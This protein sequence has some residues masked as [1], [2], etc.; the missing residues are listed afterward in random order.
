M[1]SSRRGRE[2][3]SS[4]S[5]ESRKLSASAPSDAPR[6]PSA[7]ET[8]RGSEPPRGSGT[9]T[10]TSMGFSAPSLS[11]TVA[12]N[13]MWR[14]ETSSRVGLFGLFGLF[15]G[16]V[17]FNALFA[18]DEAVPPGAADEVSP[19]RETAR[20][21]S[22]D[23]RTRASPD[24]RE[25]SVCPSEPRRRKTTLAA[26]DAADARDAAPR[27]SAPPSP[28]GGARPGGA[29]RAR[30]RRLEPRLHLRA[31]ALPASSPRRRRAS[32]DARADRRV[33]ERARQRGPGG[34]FARARAAR[35]PRPPSESASSDPPKRAPTRAPSAPSRGDSGR[36]SPR[37][38]GFLAVGTRRRGN[39][40]RR[41]RYA[42]ARG[43]LGDAEPPERLAGG[44]ARP[45][46]R[47]PPP[48]HSPGT[49]RSTRRRRAPASGARS[50]A[51]SR[52][53]SAGVV[54]H[55]GFS[56][57]FSIAVPRA[58]AC[59]RAAPAPPRVLFSISRA[60]SAA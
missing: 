26:A 11:C 2:R 35:A 21:T 53:L 19:D 1:R 50:R 6:V 13:E 58:A 49:R 10:G 42:H 45:R 48:K 46:A 18:G 14:A 23:S 15:V 3:S 56:I 5:A 12:A 24:R 34:G 41:G 7:S 29:A 22:E 47:Q 36:F 27:A 16:V 4:A 25:L 37:R 43:V 33:H 39:S 40:R 59:S 55:P 52:F 30:F 32:R 28:A 9:P 51:R 20:A 8:S 57:V 31:Q 60:A 54:S 17:F 44:R 38:R